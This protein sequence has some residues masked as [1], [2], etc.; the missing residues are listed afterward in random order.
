M[1]DYAPGEQKWSIGQEFDGASEQDGVPRLSDFFNG[2]V[3]EVRIWNVPRTHAQIRRHFK[4]GVAATATGLVGYFRFDERPSEDARYFRVATDTSKYAQHGRILGKFWWINSFAPM[5]GSDS[6]SI[7]PEFRTD[8]VLVRGFDADHD[9]SLELELTA[10]PQLGN[11]SLAGM[12]VLKGQ[13]LQQDKVL[14]GGNI[15][16]LEYAAEG[17]F[18]KASICWKASD[19]VLVSTAFLSQILS[20][21]FSSSNR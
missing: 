10:V 7:Q 19:E 13:R 8:D 21:F 14:V 6:S 1:L 3:D 9:A 18:Y 11:L 20:D 12:R 2:A 4:S 17:G 5:S 15:W 16:R